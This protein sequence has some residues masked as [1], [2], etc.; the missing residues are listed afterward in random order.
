M[1]RN[2]F[3]VEYAFHL[4]RRITR[5]TSLISNH[6]IHVM[7][8]HLNICIQWNRHNLLVVELENV[9]V[10][11]IVKWIATINNHSS[12]VNMWV[13]TELPAGT[14]PSN[15]M[16]A[17]LLSCRLTSP[18]WNCTPDARSYL[19]VVSH[20]VFSFWKVAPL[21]QL[22]TLQ[23]YVFLIMLF[24]VCFMNYSVF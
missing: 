3:I 22:M 23:V 16:T 2:T 12:C 9:K 6:S 7:I 5:L 14:Y 15:E 1:R 4:V 20:L 21:H 24:I 18:C 19:A 13:W 10:K 8:S 17:W 11:L